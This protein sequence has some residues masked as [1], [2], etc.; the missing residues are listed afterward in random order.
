MNTNREQRWY[1]FTL[2]E[3][4]VVLSIFAILAAVAIPTFA[5]YGVFS[6][7]E[8]QRS[9]LELHNLLKS[10]RVHASTYRV[11]TAVVYMLDS[12]V[13]PEDNPD[14][15]IDPATPVGVGDSLT[16][17]TLRVITGAAVIFKIPKGPY[18]GKFAPA[19]GELGSFVTFPGRMV[20]LLVNPEKTDDVYYW[21]DRPRFDP[22]DQGIGRLAMRS[23]EVVDVVA[24]VEQ[25]EILNGLDDDGDRLIDEG[26]EVGSLGF[27]PAHIFKPTGRM[28]APDGKERVTIHLSPWPEEDP[29]NRLYYP[30]TPNYL[31][32]AGQQ[33]L[34][35]IPIELYRTTGRI[36]IAR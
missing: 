1:G 23:V 27:F 24:V 2:V 25:G 28:D 9:S 5:R 4:L 20:V 15:L 32:N 36:Q 8:L 11:D 12:Y 6:K 7:N 30:E 17:A 21:S 26:L 34:I 19:S 14:N 22:T 33:N 31:D 35:T 13:P 10:A 18:A 3:I 29:E 16:G